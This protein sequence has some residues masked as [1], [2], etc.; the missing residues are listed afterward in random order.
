MHVIQNDSSVK[1]E[2]HAPF[3]G[4]DEDSTGAMQI[5]VPDLA[6]TLLWSWAAE[7]FRAC[8]T[9]RLEQFCMIYTRYVKRRHYRHQQSSRSGIAEGFWHEDYSPPAMKVASWCF[10]SSLMCSGTGKRFWLDSYRIS[11][12]LILECSGI[13]I[14]VILYTFAFELLV[15]S[16]FADWC[17]PQGMRHTF[18]LRN[19]FRD[20]EFLIKYREFHPLLAL[21]TVTSLPHSTIEWFPWTISERTLQESKAPWPF[22][23]AFRRRTCRAASLRCFHRETTI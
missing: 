7:V 5:P 21:S 1:I 6:T 8:S 23:K 10:E 2:E 22:S 4:P 9:E 13:A 16:R 20:F 19:D 18:C 14:F 11:I 17:R 15:L 3:A 12:V